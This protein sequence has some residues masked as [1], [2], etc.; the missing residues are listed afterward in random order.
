MEKKCCKAKNSKYCNIYEKYLFPA[1]IL[2][3]T[4]LEANNTSI[5]SCNNYV[6]YICIPLTHCIFIMCPVSLTYFC[7]G[8]T[9]YK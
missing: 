1:I 4:V 7:E 9:E 5:N 8:P 6:I 3:C 2:L